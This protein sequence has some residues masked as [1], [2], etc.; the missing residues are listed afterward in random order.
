[1]EFE[2]GQDFDDNIGAG[3]ADLRETGVYD[4]TLKSVGYSK[5][6]N[7]A[8]QLNIKVNAGGEYDDIF[9]QGNVKNYDGEDGFE[10]KR[11]LD[12]LAFICGVKALTRS[13]ITVDT[14]N[15]TK[16]VTIFDQFEPCKI[17]IAV[18]KTWSDYKNDWEKK[19]AKVFDANGRTASEIKT[20]KE[21]KQIKWYLS[22]KFQDKGP[23]GKATPKKEVPEV[24]FDDDFDV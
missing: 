23:K 15:G 11:L 18:Q 20:G 5:A 9:Y 6:K 21:A 2:L 4:V 12:P 19:I 8:L 24:D 7:G 13:K 10:K 3:F 14:K 17:K 1:M 16:E 22:D